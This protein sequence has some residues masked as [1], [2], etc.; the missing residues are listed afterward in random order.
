MSHDIT[1][2]FLDLIKALPGTRSPKEH[3]DLV[4]KFCSLSHDDEIL[5]INLSNEQK[6]DLIYYFLERKEQASKR[7]YD[8]AM[9]PPAA[10]NKHKFFRPT[11]GKI[12][13]KE[14]CSN[15]KKD[16]PA[17]TYAWFLRLPNDPAYNFWC[18]SFDCFPDEHKTHMLYNV[19][20]NQW[21]MES[22]EDKNE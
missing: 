20:Y 17:N 10:T 8:Y 5:I 12:S 4:C 13:Y 21:L 11:W 14:I 22:N 18:S 2:E 9:K 16:L 1:N 3:H 7:G 19:K 15:C 6:L